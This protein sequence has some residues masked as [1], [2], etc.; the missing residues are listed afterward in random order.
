MILSPHEGSFIIVINLVF[1]LLGDK[2]REGEEL[3]ETV[4]GK[5]KFYF[6]QNVIMLISKNVM[7]IFRKP[8]QIAARGVVNVFFKVSFPQKWVEILLY[9]YNQN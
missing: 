2:N 6:F 1:R 7:H 3:T 9:S 5:F 8:S 4:S